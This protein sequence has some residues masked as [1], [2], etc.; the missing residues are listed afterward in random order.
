MPDSG[1]ASE[2]FHDI[3]TTD[4]SATPEWRTARLVPSDVTS[5]QRCWPKILFRTVHKRQEDMEQLRRSCRDRPERASRQGHPGYCPEC[6]QDVGVAVR[7]FEESREVFPSMDWH[8][9]LQPGIS[10]VAVDVK[11][12]H[13]SGR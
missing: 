1:I 13:D 7:R 2:S 8:A 12:F 10:G 6:K 5:L 4:L 3:V 9:A 11:L